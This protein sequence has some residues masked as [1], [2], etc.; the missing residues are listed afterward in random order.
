MYSAMFFL[1]TFG[2]AHTGYAQNLFVSGD[3]HGEIYKFTPTGSQSTFASGLSY[4]QSLAF[5]SSGNLFAADGGSSNIYKFTPNG[6]QTTFASEAGFPLGLVFD[7]SDNLF[8]SDYV[9]GNIY[10][11]TRNGTRT[12]FASGLVRPLGLALDSSGNLFVVNHGNS[13]N[14][15][16]LKFAPDGSQSV[17]ASGFSD[18]QGLLFDSIGNLF[19]A[20]QGA[21]NVILKF[22]PDGS[23]TIFAS[24][25]GSPTFLAFQPALLKSI[26]LSPSTVTG[27]LNTMGTIT[28]TAPAP[29]GTVIT[30][31]DTNSA[32]TA[33][34]TINVPL[35]ATTATFT[36]TTTAVT[37]KTTGKITATYTGKSKTANLTV[38]PIGV[39]SLTIAPGT[40][41]GSN[42]A[43]G[44][45]TLAYPAA[46]GDITV[47]LTSGA[48]GV[49][50]PTVASITIP[51]G[52]QT[53]AF[54][55]STSVVSAL[56][57]VS[58]S[59][60]ANGVT[61]SKTINVRPIGVKSVT[62]TPNT[63]SGVNFVVGIVTLEA[64]ANPG[65]I[66]VT[67][68]SDNPLAILPVTSVTISKGYSKFAFTI[69]TGQATVTT[70]VN[71][72]ATANNVTAK[73]VLTINP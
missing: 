55:I 11:F 41:L 26:T 62:L 36:V 52:S 64:V 20:D 63:V 72:Y 48:P 47:N 43:T 30:L 39:K 1:L 28:L 57:A 12:T 34:A 35:N 51:A 32:S 2:S 46:P 66:A 24:G 14:S 60:T 54:T 3:Y 9:G 25:V 6:I 56:T 5:D 23:Q 73:R 22:A 19:V 37:S 44:T 4:P 18:P 21:A 67:L 42:N 50:N 13:G 59:A 58:I 68:S 27:S 17:F 29:N 69:Y 53:G 65:D 8:E 7:G 71:I 61:K 40:V 38:L 10:K 31:T 70:K 45:V 49:A 15:N 33:P 16:I